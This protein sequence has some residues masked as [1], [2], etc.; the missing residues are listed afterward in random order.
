MII[1]TLKNTKHENR[2]TTLIFKI[3][4][5]SGIEPVGPSQVIELLAI[6]VDPSTIFFKEGGCIA[7]VL[8]DLLHTLERVVVGRSPT[9]SAYLSAD[10]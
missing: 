3:S 1:W 6:L 9:A 8:Q 4:V 2:L 5:R 7:P 10:R